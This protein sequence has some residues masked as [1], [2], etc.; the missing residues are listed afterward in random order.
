MIKSSYNRGNSEDVLLKILCKQSSGLNVFHIN[1]QSL[2]KKIDDLR[3]LCETTSIDVICVSET[4]FRR[5]IHDSMYDLRGFKLFRSDRNSHAG[6]VAI[7]VSKSISSKVIC[8]NNVDES[9]EYL[10]VEVSSNSHKLLIG[11]VYRPR[12]NIDLSIFFRKY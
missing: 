3:F 1:A 7:Y 8:S 5:E 2:H 12:R 9:V 6:G 10:L 11:C 4:W